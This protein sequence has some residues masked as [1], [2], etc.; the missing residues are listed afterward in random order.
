MKGEN[1]GENS[2]QLKGLVHFKKKLLIIYS[3]PCHA[4]I[5]GSFSLLLSVNYCIMSIGCEMFFV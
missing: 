2:S 1:G 3:P 4:G 5:L